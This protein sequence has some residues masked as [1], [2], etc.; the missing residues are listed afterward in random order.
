MLFKKCTN[1]LFATRMALIAEHDLT[2]SSASTEFLFDS[3]SAQ[4]AQTHLS[5]LEYISLVPS[6]V[7][8][9]LS[10]YLQSIVELSLTWK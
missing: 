8:I 6:V 3:K 5:M 9:C 7:R 10:F 4:M 2:T 1:R